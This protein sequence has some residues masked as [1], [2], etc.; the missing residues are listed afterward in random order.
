MA[1]LLGP[2]QGTRLAYKV[3]GTDIRST[4]GLFA[5][6]YSDA[7]A[8][9]P[10][11]IA[12][13]D[14]TGT[15]GAVIAT[16]KVLVNP[17]SEVGLFW[18]PDSV[19]TVYMKVGASSAIY[20]LE[21]GGTSVSTQ[22]ES[23][24]LSTPGGAVLTALDVGY[25]SVI[26]VVGDST[27]DTTAEWFG[28]LGATLGARYPGHNVMWRPWNATDQWYDAP[29][30][31]Q[32]GPSGDRYVTVAAGGLRHVA[33]AIT[34]DVEIRIKLAA[35][36]WTPSALQIPVGRY[37]STGNQRGFYLGINTAG[38]LVLQWSTDGTG[39]T[40]TTATSTVA[41]GFTDGTTHWI[42]ATLDVD[43]GAGGRDA[44][45]Y[46]SDDGITWAQL[47]ATVH[48]AA[49]T[50]IHASTAPYQIG[51]SQ[52][53]FASPFA[54]NIFW[55]EIRDGLGGP[56]LVPP[57]PETWDQASSSTSDTVLVGGSPTLLLVSG[58]E[59]GRGISYW[60]DATRRPRV[61]SY[62]GQSLVMLSTNHNEGSRTGMSSAD[63]WI[64]AY[65]TWVANIKTLLP[66]VPI[67]V[68]TQNP[69][70]P[71]LAGINH[72]QVRKLRGIALMT[73]ARAQQGVGGLDVFHAFSD[74]TTQVSASDGV[75]PTAS[76]SAAWAA[77]VNSALFPA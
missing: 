15:P 26:Q 38:T 35:T 54:G 55:V 59:G 76:G 69:T 30:N 73:W 10:A 23:A 48:V 74:V 16:S 43:D 75:H 21:A 41:T 72:T 2:S 61:F 32:A 49:T 7:A 14:G 19:D 46:T 5:T 64:A 39:A 9:V 17:N 18:F 58:S 68:M 8:T 57:L 1:R 60:D 66:D 37:E 62:H 22:I 52:S 29:T 27:S 67:V 47:G 28:L 70:N 12:T 34:G 51:S 77:L 20:K 24:R 3:S 4:D 42:R 65:E 33:A 40:V 31:L 36:D 53:T 6:I 71:A 56:S 25:S 13:Y 63:F 50:S 11:N 45:F 44:N